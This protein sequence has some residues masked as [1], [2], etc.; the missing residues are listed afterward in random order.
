MST[1]L[2]AARLAGELRKRAA[3]STRWRN[4]ANR[5]CCAAGRHCCNGCSLRA[6]RRPTTCRKK[7]SSCRPTLIPFASG[8]C[9][10]PWCEPA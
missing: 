8:A 9:Q 2:D 10:R 3:G 7:Q 4:A 1:T 6:P 5:L